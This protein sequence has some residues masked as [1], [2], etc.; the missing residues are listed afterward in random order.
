LVAVALVLVALDGRR[1]GA[2]LLVGAVYSLVFF[3][4]LV[5]WTARYLGPVPWIALTVVE[6]LLTAV[7]LLPVSLA[8]RWLPRAWPGSRAVL[9]PAVVAGLWT[10]HELF[11]GNWPYGG[12]PWARLGMTQAEG[13]FAPLASWVGGSGLSLLMVFLVALV[14]ETVRQRRR[15]H[16]R[17]LLVPAATALVMLLLPSFPTAHAGSMRIAAVQGNG[18]TGYFDTREQYGVIDA[19]MSATEPLE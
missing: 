9:L 8:Y 19:Q 14:I 18:T 5:S 6:G 3:S 10:V 17:A 7:A 1:I 12:F 2:A 11:L 4:L 13:P 15:R 16:P